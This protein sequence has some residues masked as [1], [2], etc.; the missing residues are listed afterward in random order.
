MPVLSKIGVVIFLWLMCSG[1]PQPAQSLEYTRDYKTIVETD[2]SGVWSVLKPT[3]SMT[4]F[5]LLYPNGR[6]VLRKSNCA[7]MAEGTWQQNMDFLDFTNS[8]DGSKMDF[9]VIR[10][11]QRLVTGGHIYFADNGEWMLLTRDVTS[12]C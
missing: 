5:V 4:R 11:P 10:V 3:G 9:A 8:I 12:P 7:V 2:F 1:L 6:L